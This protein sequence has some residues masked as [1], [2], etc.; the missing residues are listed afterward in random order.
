MTETKNCKTCCKVVIYSNIADFNGA[1]DGVEIIL[2]VTKEDLLRKL[3]YINYER[4]GIYFL[5]LTDVKCLNKG[6]IPDGEK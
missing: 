6:V 4:S 5:E 1:E 2:P 3:G